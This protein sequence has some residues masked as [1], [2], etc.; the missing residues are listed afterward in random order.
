[1]IL[2][3]WGAEILIIK[4]ATWRGSLWEQEI[5]F[6]DPVLNSICWSKKNYIGK[7]WEFVAVLCFR[8]P[9]KLSENVES[10]F[11]CHFPR[12]QSQCRQPA[13]LSDTG[14]DGWFLPNWREVLAESWLLW[15]EVA[16]ERRIP[17]SR[18][19]SAMAISALRHQGV[20]GAESRGHLAQGEALVGRSTQ[21]M[22]HSL[23]AGAL[24]VHFSGFRLSQLLALIS[25]F[26]IYAKSDY[27]IHPCLHAGADSWK[28]VFRSRFLS[29]NPSL[30]CCIVNSSSTPALMKVIYIPHKPGP[31]V[32]IHPWSVPYLH[33]SSLS[34]G[35][36]ALL[37]WW[38][39][40][41]S[42]QR[43]TEGSQ[44]PPA[45]D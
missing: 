34:Q 4:G 42:D 5:W 32:S 3:N 38:S 16:G 26:C 31:R 40:Y 43:C 10:F 37:L 39:E 45:G 18:S 25:D 22:A 24:P 19:R 12:K 30:R 7:K 21:A 8:L 20:P 41:R 33:P 1:M 14:S 9:S 23:C 28:R 11:W 2:L 36:D 15:D 29:K 44:T 27:F 13:V 17:R 35:E 6:S